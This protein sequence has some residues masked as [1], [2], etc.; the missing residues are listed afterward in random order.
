MLIGLLAALILYKRYNA[1]KETDEIMTPLSGG[2]CKN[3][4][5]QNRW[6]QDSLPR[7]LDVTE[8]RTQWSKPPRFESL[9]KQKPGLRGYRVDQEVS[10]LVVG[11]PHRM[12]VMASRTVDD[13]RAIEASLIKAI[14]SSDTTEDGRR[15]AREALEEY[16]FV[17]RQSA[18]MLMGRDAWERSSAA[19][20]L[21]QI[22]APSRCRS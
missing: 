5:K 19:R 15:R 14:E 4:L 17:A 3:K 21:G 2:R 13:R 20:T 1:K 10:K 9:A 16:G 7:T 6:R 22:S 12:D 18:T 11:K 8:R